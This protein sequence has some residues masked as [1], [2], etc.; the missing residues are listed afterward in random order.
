MKH[1][2][3][4]VLVGVTRGAVRALRFS[5]YVLLL[6]LGRV[7]QPVAS[8]ATVIGSVVFLFCLFV[9]PDLSIPMWAGAGLAAGALAVAAFYDALLRLVVPRDVVIVSEV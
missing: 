8:L 4:K 7:L 3:V 2:G 5:L 6:L 1:V 9:H